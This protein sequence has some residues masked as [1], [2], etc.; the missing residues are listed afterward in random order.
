MTLYV[1]I[2]PGLSG[3]VA[4]LDAD[5]NVEDLFDLPVTAKAHGKG[6]QL[7][8]SELAGM[9]SPLRNA[10]VTVERVN[11]MPK[12]GVVSVFG[13]GFTAG[14][15]EGIVCALG[16][17]LRYATP[18]EWKREFGLV[19]KDKDASRTLCI[20]MWPRWAHKLDRKK[21]NGRSDALLIAEYARRKHNA[22]LGG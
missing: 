13:F 16:M 11:A 4:V 3:A 12:Q 2:D 19:G 22:N 6:N 20:Q 18:Q 10:K 5:G 21:D 7:S 1:G 8:C 9:M 17:P 14:A 15:I